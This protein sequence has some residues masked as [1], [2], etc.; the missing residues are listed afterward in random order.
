M[1]LDSW[2]VAYQ[3]PFMEVSMLILSFKHKN[4][5]A[6]V[7]PMYIS[8]V[9]K[10]MIDILRQLKFSSLETTNRYRKLSGYHTKGYACLMGENF[11]Y[12]LVVSILGK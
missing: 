4:S 12:R 1:T 9:I 7:V 5:A 11:L 6:K 3:L 2:H 10:E 8:K